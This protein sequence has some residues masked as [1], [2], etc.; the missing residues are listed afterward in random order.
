MFT[1]EERLAIIAMIRR[2]VV[3]A[4]G[5]TE[6][7]AVALAVARAREI[8]GE[9][10]AKITVYLSANMLKNAMG[11][12]IPGTGMTGLPIAIALG[13]LCGNSEK[14]LE[15]LQD[16]TLADVTRGKEI[17]AAG[18]IHIFLKEGITEKLY[19][20]V[21]CEGKTHGASSHVIIAGGHTRFIYLARGEEVLL[22]HRHRECFEHEVEPPELTVKR[23]YEFATEA[24]FSEIAFILESAR[25]NKAA[26]EVSFTGHYGHELGRMMR[27]RY[28]KDLMGESLFSRILA[29]TSAACDARMAGEKIPVMS[30]SG[31][32]NQGISAT[33]PVVIF[34]EEKGKSEEELARALILSHL[35]AIYIKNHMGRLAAFCGCVVAATGSSCG[36]TRLMGGGYQQITYA[37]KNMIANLTGMVCDGAKPSC[38]LKVASGVSTA[39]FSAMMAMENRYVTS[40]EGIIE[41]NPDRCIRNL[42]SVGSHGMGETDKLVLHIMTH[43]EQP[44]GRGDAP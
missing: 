34:A 30:N 31:S 42:A 7:V 10:P 9:P 18:T 44:R 40:L 27:G 8:L 43:K 38:S 21:C 17:I 32:G 41:E 19:I 15:V 24:P 1:K 26:A 13:A 16:V 37:V 35:T 6:P 14:G 4:V 2:E 20:E 12:G 25:M 36:I 3:P 22:D 29:Y 28:E 5:C 11:V 39:V 33:L 23:V